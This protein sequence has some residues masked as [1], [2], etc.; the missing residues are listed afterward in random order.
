MVSI[1]K[2]TSRQIANKFLIDGFVYTNIQ[3]YFGFD[4]DPTGYTLV[5]MESIDYTNEYLLIF[6]KTIYD[7]ANDCYN[8]KLIYYTSQYDNH[9][10]DFIEAEINNFLK[11][12]GKDGSKIT[13]CPEFY[14]DDEKKRRL[15]RDN[16][17]VE[18]V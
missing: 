14:F 13:I 9:V 16:E 17:F 3:V 10:I 18:S 4:E 1:K 15:C 5:A 6:T 7:D 2:V 12:I 11:I 8:E